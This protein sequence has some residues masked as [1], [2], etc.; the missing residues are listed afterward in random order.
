MNSSE[1]APTRAHPLRRVARRLDAG[2]LRR[3]TLLA[4]VLLS[5]I[6]L[7]VFGGT[8]HAV[9]TAAPQSATSSHQPAKTG[10]LDCN[11]DS[12]VQSALHKSAACTDI[13]GFLGTDN[14]NT[15][16]GRFYDN[17]VYIGH[18]EPDMTFLSNRPGSGNNVT[19]TETLGTDPAA[20]PTVQTPGKDVSH[21]FELTPAPWFSMAMCDPKSYPQATCSPESDSN[22]AGGGGSAFMEMQFYPPGMAPFVD[23]TS[24]DNSHWCAALTIDSLACTA[25]FAQCNANCEE[26]VNFAF[27]Q[28]NGVPAGPP[29]P[30]DSD[31]TSY[32]PNANTLLMNPGDRVSVTMNDAPIPGTPRAKAFKVTVHDRT[33]GRS[34]SMQASAANGFKNT[35]MA[36][37]SGTPFNFQPEYNTAAKGNIVPWAAL[38]TNISTQF[39]TGHFEP[40]TSL[41]Q[42]FSFPV[43]STISDT[44]WNQCAGPYEQSATGGDG[45]TAP[46]TGDAYC[47]PAGDTHGALATAPD[48]VTG[49]E[50]NVF[51]NGDLDFD[52]S[53]YWPEWPTSATAGTYPGSFVQSLPSSRGK[54]YSQ[55]FIQTDL[56]LSESTCTAGSLSGCG[57]PAPNSPGAFYPYW[58]EAASHGHCTLEFGNVSGGPGVTDF[59]KT[60][61]YGSNQESSLGYPEFEGPTMNN[62]CPA[63]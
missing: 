53:P 34:G 30:Q 1:P 10:E 11:G 13:R 58:S 45:P 32:T 8:I 19:W 16:G 21:W 15:W 46:E 49:C 40:C 37:C 56:A 48:L 18:D 60:A 14:A 43:S 38:Q 28:I 17:G 5:A 9:A 2:R 50:D 3:A 39:E 55:L 41:A 33:T 62:S 59:G 51:Q 27:I 4:T 44:S 12:P 42:E 57:V 26:P 63:G 23:S 22:A 24:C 25:G 36:D 6:A 7:A 29:S 47:Y 54:A 35:S 52:G 20:M 61:Q 31:L